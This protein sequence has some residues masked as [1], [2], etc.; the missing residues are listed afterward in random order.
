MKKIHPAALIICFLLAS[1]AQSNQADTVRVCNSQ[2][3][4]DRSRQAVSQELNDIPDDGRIAAL[5]NIA[6][7]TP[8][9]A[10]DLGLRYFRGDGVPQDSY[11]AITWMR[12][13]AEQGELEAQKALGRVYL[14]GLEEMGPDSR[15]AQKWLSIASSRGDAEAS[16]LLAQAE[17]ARRSDEAEWKWRQHWRGI[18]YNYWYSGYP[19]FGRWQGTYWIY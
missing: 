6:K 13:A 14:T 2:G 18:F 12:A 10:Y 4:S 8:R 7:Q 19:Y 16:K 1:C 15:E 5:E 3:C 9:A 11:K 17:A